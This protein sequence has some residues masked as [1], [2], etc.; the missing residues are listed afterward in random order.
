VRRFFEKLFRSLEPYLDRTR[1]FCFGL[2][3]LLVCLGVAVCSG[4][5][6][7]NQLTVHRISGVY[8]KPVPGAPFSGMVEIVTRQK[9]PDGSVSVLKSTN[10]I[11]RDSLGR[12]HNESRRMVA[13][14]YQEKPPLTDIQL[15]DPAT[16]LSTH[17]DPFTFIAKQTAL[18]APPAPS[19]DSVPAPNPNDLA[20]PVKQVDDLGARVSQ[21]LTLHG[22]RQSHDATDFD[23]YWYS[24][25]L[26]IFMSHRHQ[27]PVWE[28]TV[29]IV[30]LNRKEPDPA[31]FT[32]PANYKIVAVA[33]R[34][35]VPDAS[36]TYH[37]GNGVLPPKLIYAVDPQFSPQARK[38]K[39]GG[40]ATVS[41]I[42]DAQGNPQN[43]QIIQHLK[44]GLDEEAL[45]AVKKYK[46][47]PATL[48][49]K[50]VPVVVNITV[51]FRIY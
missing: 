21:N 42:V 40:I 3:A 32:V 19:A 25:D 37:V 22:T 51:N 46:F 43:V 12:T 7:S 24:P 15:F 10:Y 5:E 2:V 23:E 11:A 27:D 16:N 9:L 26:S 44:M 20:S 47:K 30:E 14:A 49:G 39:Y 17:L 50:P 29:N 33:E 48:E 8:I 41:F 34:L 6:S 13:A 1:V 45:A 4:Q 31:N 35:P 28:Q 38:A 36:G 18:R